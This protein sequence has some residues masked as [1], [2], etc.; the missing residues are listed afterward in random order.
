MAMVSAVANIT[1]L[2]AFHRAH[3]RLKATLTATY[4]PGRFGAS[5]FHK[6]QHHRLQREAQRRWQE[7]RSM[8]DPFTALISLIA[9]VKPILGT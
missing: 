4:P 3:G 1:E 7:R 2:I 9:N 8:V 5:I 6:D